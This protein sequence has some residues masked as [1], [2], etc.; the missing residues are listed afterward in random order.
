MLNQFIANIPAWVYFLL[1]FLIY[2]GWAQS[3]VR[4]VSRTR[5][6]LLP[7]AMIGLSLFGVVSVFGAALASLV[8]WTIA[9]GLT[10]QLTYYFS[11]RQATLHDISYNQDSRTFQLPGSWVPMFLIMGIFVTK[12]FVGAL[13]AQGLALLHDASV[14]AGVCA[15]YGLFSGAFFS[16][17]LVVLRVGKT[18]PTQSAL[19]RPAAT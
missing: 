4:E 19:S 18:E 7:L 15:L 10:A 1:A 3:K 13:T 5:L 16:R 12:F 17:A 6:V 2:L 8:P 9:F 14:M 11:D